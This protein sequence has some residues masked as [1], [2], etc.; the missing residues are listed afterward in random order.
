MPPRGW[1]EDGEAERSRP[2][3]LDDR[4]ARLVGD[5]LRLE[6]AARRAQRGRGRAGEVEPGLGDGLREVRPLGEEAVAG[7]DRVGVG[8]LR[9]ANVLGRIEVRRDLDR[10]VGGPGVERT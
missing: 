9:R 3:R 4:Y 8:L 6:L 7:V 10:P 1:D 2:A 5:P